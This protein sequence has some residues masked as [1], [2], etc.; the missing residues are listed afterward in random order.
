M[1][2]EQAA[3]VGAIETR[4]AGA[5]RYRSGRA[6]HQTD[7]VATLER[8]RDETLGVDERHRHQGVVVI[9]RRC[10]GDGGF[11]DE[12]DLIGGERELLHEGGYCSARADR[13]WS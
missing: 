10:C 3:K 9:E 11:I 7:E 5:F 6:L 1:P 2:L 4:E 8:R 13:R 12:G